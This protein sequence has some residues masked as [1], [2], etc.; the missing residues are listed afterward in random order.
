MIEL[1]TRPTLDV[2]PFDEG[3][4]AD[5]IPVDTTIREAG[6]IV[7]VP[8]YGFWAV[9]RD[10][11]CRA[12]FSD[13]ENFSSSFGTGLTNIK[14]ETPWRRPSVILDADPPLHTASRRILAKVLSPAVV[15][16]LHEDFMQEADRMVAALVE[17][18]RFDAAEDLAFAFPFKVLPDAVGMR[19]E[20][21]EHLMP[22]AALNFNAMGPKNRL[23][24]EA[25]VEAEGAAEYVRWQC[26]RENLEP[27]KF[28]AQIYELAEEAQMDP[29]DAALLVRA[30]LSAGID[31]TVYGIGLAI[32]ALASDPEQWAL[33]HADPGLAR[34]A[35]E[36]SLRFSAPSPIIGRTTSQA[37]E[38][39]GVQLG[40][41]EKVLMFL[42]AANRDPRR[43]DDPD[44]Y[45]IRRNPVGH[46]AL[47]TGIHGC[48]GQVIA[49]LEAESVLSALA[50]RVKRI[51]LAGQPEKRLCNWLRGFGSLP[52]E[53]EPA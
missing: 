22:Y 52:V 49:R 34:T 21:R 35:F 17:R 29:E 33:L 13:W 45:D 42:A 6:P 53:V 19:N 10:A 27:G 11:E 18:G 46:L 7:W 38:F 36:E 48:V 25:L 41:E 1:E 16:R 47:G 26:A 40:A 3:V 4:L 12:I 24:E 50:R 37:V 44:S 43:W 39:R 8:K 2:D 15:A 32:H 9:G 14:R 23:Y 20:G 51:S 5:P 28:G 31:T 30:F